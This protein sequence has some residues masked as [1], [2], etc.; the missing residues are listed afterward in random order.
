MEHAF[1]AVLHDGLVLLPGNVPERRPARLVPSAD[2]TISPTSGAPVISSSVGKRSIKDA[3]EPTRRPPGKVPGQDRIDG[4][5]TA[6]SM[7]VRLYHMPCSPIISP[8]LVRRK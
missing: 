4:T 1:R 7:N 5:L 8:E 3:V 6:S 2:W